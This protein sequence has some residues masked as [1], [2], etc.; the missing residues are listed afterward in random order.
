MRRLPLS[1]QQHCEGDKN[2]GR[3]CLTAGGFRGRNTRITLSLVS[4]RCPACPVVT[5]T[6][7]GIL[8]RHL[9]VLQ[10]RERAVLQHQEIRALVSVAGLHRDRETGQ[11]LQVRGESLGSQGLVRQV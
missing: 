4:F 11:S 10:V 7:I 2:K 3:R 1:Q 9:R 6:R 8:P 5:L